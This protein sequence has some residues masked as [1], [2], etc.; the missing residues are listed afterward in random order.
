MR[1][2]RANVP[3]RS[4][5]CSGLQLAVFSLKVR[6]AKGW[7]EKALLLL[8]NPRQ[9]GHR[10]RRKAATDSD[11]KRPAN[12]NAGGHPVDRGSRGALSAFRTG[13]VPHLAFHAL[14]GPNPP[15]RSP[16]PPLQ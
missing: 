15:T 10:F 7:I 13:Q 5:T 8:R 16:I 12:P 9:S 4:A 14:G 2:R 6:L 3:T 1:S 11:R